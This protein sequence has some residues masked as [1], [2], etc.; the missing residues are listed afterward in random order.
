MPNYV[1]AALDLCNADKGWNNFEV[2]D[3]NVNI[4]RDSGE[5]SILRKLRRKQDPCYKV[6]KTLDELCSRVYEKNREQ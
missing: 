5:I 3:T 4:K 2:Y 6:E 1:K